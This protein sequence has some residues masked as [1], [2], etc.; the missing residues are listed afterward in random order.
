[1]SNAH[2]Q[3]EHFVAYRN[4]VP[5]YHADL[6]SVTVAADGSVIMLLRNCGPWA[7][8]VNVEHGLPTF[9]DADTQIIALRCTDA[10]RCFE[11]VGD[12]P[13]F[14]GLVVEPMVLQLSDGALLACTIY[15]EAGPRAK[16]PQMKGVLHR[17][18]PQLN[19]VI[20]FAGIAARRS[21]DNGRSWTEPVRT[22][23]GPISLYQTRKAVELKDG[24]LILPLAVGYPSRSRY[25]SMLQSW[26]MGLTW[27]DETLVAEDERG[28]SRW[29]AGWDYW[30]P[31][32][33]VTD[34]ENL[35][36]VMVEDRKETTGA[37]LYDGQLVCA[38]SHGSGG[39]WCLPEPIGIRGAFPDVTRLRDGRFLLVFL[40]RT[41]A[42]ARLEA[43]LSNDEG[44][45]WQQ[46]LTLH[47]EADCIFHSPETVE[48]ADGR[49]LTVYT[50]APTTGAARVVAAVCWRPVA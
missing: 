36:C 21:T 20:T 7:Y 47:T 33:G 35:F 19:T 5:H 15:G 2:A 23:Y 28:R 24:A 10:G 25:V 26:D 48:L 13:V 34:A 38:Q 30:Q 18:F 12:Q 29:I 44:R 50:S 42:G 16:R 49:L 17:H 41:Q 45:T 43:A 1:M 22:E 3:L 14:S 46:S 32:L 37:G 8:K 40:Q 27:T 6:A 4:A 31:S 39:V 9:F 11:R